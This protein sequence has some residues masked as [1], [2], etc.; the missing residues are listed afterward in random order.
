MTVRI[1]QFGTTGQV[2]REMIRQA[3]AHDV[4]LTALSREDCDFEDPEKAARLVNHHHP[5]LVVIAAAYTAVDKAEEEPERVYEINAETP[6]AIAGVCGLN[7]PAIVHFST[8]YV[9]DGDKGFPYVEEDRPHPIN[10]YGEMKL[11]GENN[12]LSACPRALVLRT[13]WVVSSHG[14][15]FVKTMLRLAGEGN[16]IRVVDDQFGRPTAAAD[17]AGFVLSQA[18]RLAAAKAG[19]PVFGLFHFAN[20]GETSWK[21]FAEGIFAEALGERAPKVEAIATADRPAPA[22]RP[23]RGTLDTGKLERVFGVT[24]RPWRAALAEIVADL[25]TEGAAA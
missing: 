18:S 11:S 1:L 5:D 20:D 24:P 10:V 21:G 2:A 3:P 7:G 9:F 8:D 15:N 25:K 23:L 16:P 6:G 4:A 19:D 12:V 17:L 13:S 22:R 14:R